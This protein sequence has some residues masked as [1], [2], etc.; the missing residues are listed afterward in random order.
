MEHI[1]TIVQ[2]VLDQVSE[3]SESEPIV[4]EEDKEEEEDKELVYA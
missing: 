1:A 4:M 3:H 2:E